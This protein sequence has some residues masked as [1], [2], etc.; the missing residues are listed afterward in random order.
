MILHQCNDVM[1]ALM[2]I[3]KEKK[4]WSELGA[5]VSKI[6]FVTSRR[7]CHLMLIFAHVGAIFFIEIKKSIK[8]ISNSM[9]L[10]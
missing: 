3:S 2:C 5:S 6:L 1:I 8:I 9:C 7:T 10:I 4:S